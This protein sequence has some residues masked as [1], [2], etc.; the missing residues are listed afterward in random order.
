MSWVKWYTVWHAVWDHSPTTV[1]GRRIPLAEAK[2]RITPP[3]EVFLC[4]TCR[5]GA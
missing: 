1:C 4:S 3:G 2:R 5:K